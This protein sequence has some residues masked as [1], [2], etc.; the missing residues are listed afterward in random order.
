MIK[1]TCM[2][3][4]I[5]VQH[6]ITFKVSHKNQA[7]RAF[8]KFGATE[9]RDKLIQKSH[10]QILLRRGTSSPMHSLPYPMS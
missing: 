7:V 9:I 6:L 10:K 8:K 2:E 3:N 1:T 5:K 4:L